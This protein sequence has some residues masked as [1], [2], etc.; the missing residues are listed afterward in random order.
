VVSVLALPFYLMITYSGLIFMGFSYMPLIVA[1]HYGTDGRQQF[2]SDIFD[3]PGLI[4]PAR[5]AAVLTPLSS[6]ISTAEARWG[7]G[8][9]RSID[10]RHPGD[11]NARIILSENIGKTLS[12]NGER[13]VF[14]GTSGQLLHVVAPATSAAK[15][16]R[17]LFIGLHEGL[18]APP[19]LRWL[20]FL[21]GLLGTAMIATGLVLWSIKRRQQA[22]RKNGHISPGLF[23]VERLNIATI[24]GLP[25]AIAAYFWANRLLPLTWTNRADWETHC[26]FLL[27]AV[28]LVHSA[29][30]PTARAWLEQLSVTAAAF[31]LLPILNLLTTHRHLGQSLNS[32]DWVFAGFDLTVL[33]IGLVFAYAAR[34]VR[35]K[36]LAI[37]AVVSRAR[38]SCT[39]QPV[40][41]VP[42]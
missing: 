25:I 1:A 15:G 20:Y 3:P 26:M 34:K 39:V 4:E 2:I 19:V 23:L 12:S 17:D 31:A 9:I 24:A 29:C 13:L 7:D 6:L 22:V 40:P 5:Q 35:H 33:A 11:S 36:Q 30:R 14:D 37:N 41:E 27:W 42:I 38:A 21:S 28:M 16:T 8:R 10:I 18:F 32:G